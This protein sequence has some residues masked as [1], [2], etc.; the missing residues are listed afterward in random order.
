MPHGNRPVRHGSRPGDNVCEQPRPTAE[1]GE[2][3]PAIAVHG[4]IKRF[5]DRV[6]FHDG[7][8]EVG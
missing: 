2:N 1:V 7:S 6:A 3:V 4:L 8:F 5:G